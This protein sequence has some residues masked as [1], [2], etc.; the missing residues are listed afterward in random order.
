MVSLAVCLSNRL[1][2]QVRQIAIVKPF[3]NLTPASEGGIAP[4]RERRQ[5]DA[6][7][8]SESV[9]RSAQLA[10]FAGHNEY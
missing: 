4:E 6:S 8:G 10:D 3:T 2:P 7:N 1:T 9:T 5:E